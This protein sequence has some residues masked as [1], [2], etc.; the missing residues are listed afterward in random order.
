MQTSFANELQ[1]KLS[2]RLDSSH[3]YLGF[4]NFLMVIVLEL[5]RNTTLNLNRRDGLPLYD[6]NGL[7]HGG[8]RKKLGNCKTT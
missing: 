2:S 3:E 4:G 5:Y 1:V 8:R 6:G 7:K